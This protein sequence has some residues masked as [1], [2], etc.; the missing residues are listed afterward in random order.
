MARPYCPLPVVTSVGWVLY[1]K[2]GG[3]RH[4]KETVGWLARAQ[5]KRRSCSGLDEP[6]LAVPRDAL[7]S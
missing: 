3:G 1:L 5:T 2:G 7:A 6:D 4:N